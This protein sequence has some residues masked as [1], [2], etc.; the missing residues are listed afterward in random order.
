MQVIKVLNM[1]NKGTLDGQ[2]AN[3]TR[4]GHSA[5]WSELPRAT[6][7]TRTLNWKV[8]GLRNVRDEDNHADL[9][10]MQLICL[11]LCA[12]CSAASPSLVSAATFRPPW[13]LSGSAGA[14]QKLV[15]GVSFYELQFSRGTH[16]FLVARFRKNATNTFLDVILMLNFKH[17]RARVLL[18]SIW[19]C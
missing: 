7:G 17:F 5:E 6:A 18:S 16:N 1:L 2:N 15:R 3:Y 12:K 8:C 11:I 4:R 14:L 19:L 9:V 10:D 13:T